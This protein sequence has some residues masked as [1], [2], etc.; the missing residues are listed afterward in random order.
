MLK[1]YLTLT[2]ITIAFSSP[3]L[4]GTDT[5]RP[6]ISIRIEVSSGPVYA[7]TRVPIKVIIRNES[8]KP[9]NLPWPKW[10]DS[11]LATESKQSNGL[12]LT[13][14]HT[15]LS[16][17]HG[18]YPGGDI[19]PDHSITVDLWHIF[20]TPWVHDLQVILDTT[21]SDG[22]WPFWKGHLESPIITVRAKKKDGG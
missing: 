19:K 13:I 9:V 11:F 12:S 5:P 4:A 2:F 6:P 3:S 18:K 10:I 22:F 8:N 16:L 15:G 21:R 20:P 1:A 17:G 14:R 7:E